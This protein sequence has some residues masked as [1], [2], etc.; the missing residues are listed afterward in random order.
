MLPPHPVPPLDIS[1]PIRNIYREQNGPAYL[2]ISLSL[3]FFLYPMFDAYYK[4]YSL[5]VGVYAAEVGR[6][7]Q[8]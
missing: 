1:Y 3:P 5:N 6:Y 7:N 2:P 8:R 4:V